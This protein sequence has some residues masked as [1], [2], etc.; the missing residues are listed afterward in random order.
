V[1]LIDDVGPGAVGLDAVAFIYFIEEHPTYL[2]VL[3]PL[4]AEAD[5]GRTLV[6]SALTLHEVLVVPVRLGNLSLA[7]RYDAV[8]TESRGVR[9]I[10]I[11]LDQLR[12][13]ARLRAA[14][15]I[16][17]PDA[18]HLTAAMTQG[19]RCFVTNDRR[20]PDIPGLNVIQ[21]SSYA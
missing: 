6:T 2:P 21:L 5:K 19:C 18:L 16:K 10:D 15:R 8:L 12:A 14:S 11:T 3:Q 7:D 1:G 20:L 4:F 13:A 17:T 9:L